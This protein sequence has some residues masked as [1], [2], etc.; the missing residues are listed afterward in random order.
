MSKFTFMDDS[1][2]FKTVDE[3]MT[4][5]PPDTR[6]KLQSIRKAIKKAVPKAE[7]LISYNMPMFKYE[8]RL[9]YYAGYK[10]HIGLYPMVSGISAFKK[11][12]SGYKG[13]KGSVQFPLDKT[14]PL[15]LITRIVKFRAK[16]NIEK[17]AA[18]K[19]KKKK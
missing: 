10:N 4:A 11:E 8:G 5:F 15:G 9:V 16:E 14:M 19:I 1:K 2:R 3:Y 7:E 13:A 6:A 18:K 12:L 17:I